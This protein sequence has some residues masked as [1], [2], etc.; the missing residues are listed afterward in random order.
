[1]CTQCTLN[2]ILWFIKKV[3]R[4]VHGV[5][6]WF[7][8]CWFASGLTPLPHTQ[9]AQSWSTARDK[10]HTHPARVEHS[11]QPTAAAKKK[12][13]AE[14]SAAV[15]LIQATIR[16]KV[17]RTPNSNAIGAGFLPL[18]RAFIAIAIIQNFSLCHASQHP[19]MA[20]YIQC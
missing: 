6:R 9:A 13:E 3:M 17:V 10:V 15:H 14:V 8:L 4:L 18:V 1:M 20:R 12:F 19:Y 16:A 11:K 5:S 7:G 2:C